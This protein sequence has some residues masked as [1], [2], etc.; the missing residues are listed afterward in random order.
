M[1]HP[2]DGDDARRPPDRRDRRAGRP[3]GA[4]AAGRGADVE[5]AERRRRHEHERHGLRPRVGGGGR[6]AGRG[7]HDAR[8]ASWASRSRRSPG[9]SPASRR[10][11][12]RARRRS[13]P[14]R[15]P[16]RSTTPRRGPSPGP[17]SSSSLVKAAVHGRDPNWGRVAAPRATRGSRTRGPRGGRPA[18]GRG[19]ARAAGAR[20]RSTRT[21]SGSRSPATSSSTDRTA[22]R[23]PSTAPRP[24]RRW[25]R[26]R[27]SSASTSGWATGAGEAFG[28]D[29]TE[30]YVI[31]NSEYTT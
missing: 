17:S 5:P 29:L 8:R 21:G 7:R 30:A 12:A 18:R 16:A 22:A 9:T 15:S 20:P 24:G 10:P 3:P 31:E 2:A 6:R 23:S 19:G 11:T 1:I 14:A 28:C 4:P 26:R 13:S 27:S 25:T